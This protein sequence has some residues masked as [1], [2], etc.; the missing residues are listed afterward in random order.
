VKYFFYQWRDDALDQTICELL[1]CRVRERAGRAEDPGLVVL[2]A[3]SVHA[4]TNV[5][6]ATTGKDAGQEQAAPPLLEPQPQ[7]IQERSRQMGT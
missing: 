4:A 5:P 6:A 2:D 7:R 3:Q 1:R